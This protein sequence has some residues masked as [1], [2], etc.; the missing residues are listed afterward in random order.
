MRR[1]VRSEAIANPA[2]GAGFVVPPASNQAAKLRSLMFTLTTDI[3]VANRVP[4]VQLLDQNGLVV[5]QASASAA[6]AASLVVV[7]VVSDA[8]GA[9]FAAA[10]V[11]G[12]GWPDIW[13]PPNWEVKVTVGAIDVADQVSAI[14]V[15]QEFGWTAWERDELRAEFAQAAQALMAG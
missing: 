15:A 14:A 2:A 4:A 5:Y 9:P 7:Y 12:I 1:P 3:V 10:G 11:S 13:L 8:F 6:Q